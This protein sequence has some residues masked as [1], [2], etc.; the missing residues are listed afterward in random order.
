MAYTSE[1]KSLQAYNE[2]QVRIV[3]TMAGNEQNYPGFELPKDNNK[4]NYFACHVL[5]VNVMLQVYQ[6]SLT[7]AHR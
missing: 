2:V 1:Y 6:C 4:Y 7:K 3:L 5:P